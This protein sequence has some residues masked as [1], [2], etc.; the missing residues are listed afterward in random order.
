MNPESNLSKSAAD[1]EPVGLRLI[2][3]THP[4][5]VFL[6]GCVLTIFI[7]WVLRNE[8]YR[9]DALRFDRHTDKIL[10]SISSRMRLEMDARILSV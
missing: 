10:A 7:V 9:N 1:A 6:I 8:L 5:F 3:F 2:G 4:A